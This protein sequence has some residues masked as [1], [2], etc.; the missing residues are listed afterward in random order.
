MPNKKEVIFQTSNWLTGL[1]NRWFPLLHEIDPKH[2]RILSKA[3]TRIFAEIGMSL[4]DFHHSSFY[5]TRLL[6]M[7]EH[8]LKETLRSLAK[9]F[10]NACP[11]FADPFIRPSQP[12]GKPGDVVLK[13]VCRGA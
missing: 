5:Q 8:N 2:F 9:F 12:E 7:T 10:Q 6:V 3:F 4:K 1:R 13:G 11:F